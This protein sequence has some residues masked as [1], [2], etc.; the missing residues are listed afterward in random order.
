VELATKEDF[1][2][3]AQREKETLTNFYRRFQQL[4]AQ[5]PEVSD[6]QVIAQAIKALQAGTLH[7]HLV[8]ERPKIV[9]EL[10]KQFTEFSKS[11]VQYFRK[12]EQQRKT[13]KPDEAPRLPHYNDSQRSYPKPVHNINSDDLGHQRFGRRI[14]GHLRKKET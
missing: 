7:S 11:E 1:L 5:A 8:S 6:D 3:C 4:K 2:S 9:A 12:L 13:S 10:Y 14:L